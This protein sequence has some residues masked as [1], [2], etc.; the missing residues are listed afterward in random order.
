MIKIG[1][2]RLYVKNQYDDTA[3]CEHITVL[4]IVEKTSSNYVEIL[5]NEE[6]YTYTDENV[7]NT[8][9]NSKYDVYV[10]ITV[11]QAINKYKKSNESITWLNQLTEI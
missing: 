2:V 10:G 3:F 6:S 7:S 9:T 4:N 11:E 1:R 8:E 5:I